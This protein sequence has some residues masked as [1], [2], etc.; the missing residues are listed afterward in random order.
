MENKDDSSKV[1]L[2]TSQLPMFSVKPAGNSSSNLSDWVDLN[3]IFIGII[4]LLS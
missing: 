1:P 4:Y 2:I 3:D